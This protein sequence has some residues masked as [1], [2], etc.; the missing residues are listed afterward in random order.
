MHSTAT[1][2]VLRM[3][4]T[5]REAGTP[6][7]AL[8]RAVYFTESFK[9]TECQPLVLRWAKALLYRIKSSRYWWSN[10]ERT[11][12]INLRRSSLPSRIRLLSDGEIITN[13][14]SPI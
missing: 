10:C 2:R 5:I 12:S 14:N 9:A 11:I 6:R 1:D 3:F 7:V 4:E 8:E 13:G